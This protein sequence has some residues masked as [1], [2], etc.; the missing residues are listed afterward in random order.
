MNVDFREFI[1]QAEVRASAQESLLLE[2]Q[3]VFAHL[4]ESVRR[5]IEPSMLV[6]SIKSYEGGPIDIHNQM[7]ADEF[8][9]ML[10]EQW[11]GQFTS[12]NERNKFKSFYGGQL[13]QQI[14]S[15]ECEHVSEVT[16]AF[17]AIQCDIKGKRSLVESLKD[18]V[19]GELLEGCEFSMTDLFD[20]VVFG[21]LTTCAL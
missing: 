13:V 10:F 11:E 16:E 15:K 14:K 4:Q 1:L 7:D 8:F 6:N 18:Y 5:C 20:D 2:V 17:S 12:T 3:K 9:N 21:K 19:G